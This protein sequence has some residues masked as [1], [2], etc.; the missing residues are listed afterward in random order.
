VQFALGGGRLRQIGA[1]NI[2]AH[3]LKHSHATRA[4]GTAATRRPVDVALARR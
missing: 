1:L 3:A 4:A 2:V